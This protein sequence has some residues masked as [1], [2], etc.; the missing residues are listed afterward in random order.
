[1]TLKFI[2]LFQVSGKGEIDRE[3]QSVL[4]LIAVASDTPQGGANQR[5]STVPVII[6]VLK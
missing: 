4:K 5:K 1:M 6:C 3:K 2:F